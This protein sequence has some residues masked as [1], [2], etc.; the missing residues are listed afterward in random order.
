[1]PDAK[2]RERRVIS[3][4]KM[5]MENAER[6]ADRLVSH[7]GEGQRPAQSPKPVLAWWRWAPARYSPDPSC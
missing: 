1:M 3:I 4:V 6:C 2:A 7:S 5:Q